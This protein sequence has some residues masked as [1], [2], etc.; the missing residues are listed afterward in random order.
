MID[1]TT[2][3]RLAHF[4]RSA[5]RAEHVRIEALKRMSGG[6]VQQNWALD[7]EIGGGQHAGVQRW[8]LRMD[9]PATVAESLT[10]SE[11]FR[12]LEAMHAARVLAPR[13]LWL[14]DDATVTG[15]PFFIM[16]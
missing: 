14:C 16:E 8:V 5:S 4:I 1:E 11:E 3:E 10:R 7:V 6:A 9:A 2:R 12:V 13:P 15:A